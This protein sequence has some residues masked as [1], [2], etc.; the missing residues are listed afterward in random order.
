M[1]LSFLVSPMNVLTFYIDHD[2]FEQMIADNGQGQEI[3]DFFVLR[4]SEYLR[5]T[6]QPKGSL[7]QNLRIELPKWDEL[8]RSYREKTAASDDQIIMC[9]VP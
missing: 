2:Q 6:Y 5:F 9:V 8:I 7:T 4:K 1:S 3:G